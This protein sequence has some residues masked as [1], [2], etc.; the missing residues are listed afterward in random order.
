VGRERRHNRGLTLDDPEA[1][2]DAVLAGLPPRPEHQQV[3]VAANRGGRPFA[4]P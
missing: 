2:A 1:F 4:R 3:I